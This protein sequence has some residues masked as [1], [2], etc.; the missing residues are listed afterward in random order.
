VSATTSVDRQSGILSLS[1]CTNS[2]SQD[3]HGCGIDCLLNPFLPFPCAN[4]QSTCDWGNIFANL[5]HTC[6]SDGGWGTFLPGEP[7]PY[8]NGYMTTD[9]LYYFLSQSV[10]DSTSCNQNPA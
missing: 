4:Y 2:A 3:G 8:G 1:G 5:N 9:E 6:G 10:D 7:G